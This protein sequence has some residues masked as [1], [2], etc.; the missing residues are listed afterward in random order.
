ML[1][2]ASTSDLNGW[3]VGGGLEYK[4]NPSWSLKAEYLRFNFGRVTNNLAINPSANCSGYTGVC[5]YRNNL[6]IGTV[7]VGFNYFVGGGHDP[8]K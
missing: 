3:T 1:P 4:I 2:F 6:T 8:L 5:P 7:K